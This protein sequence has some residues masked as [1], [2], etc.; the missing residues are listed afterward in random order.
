M[1]K[2]LQVLFDD[3]DLEDIQRL[4][5]RERKTTATWVREQLRAARASALYPDVEP[6]LRAIREATTYSF[7]TGE[8]DELLADIE[9]G[10]A[11]SHPDARARD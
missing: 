9:R 3:D 1:T 4:A 10:Y 6:K 11:D 8:I 5:K 2:R 7:P